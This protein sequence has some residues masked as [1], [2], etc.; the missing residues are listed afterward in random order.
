MNKKVK[1]LLCFIAVPIVI[2]AL[3]GAF[4][5][6]IWLIEKLSYIIIP[7]VV[8]GLWVCAATGLYKEML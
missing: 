3:V 4:V 6:I 2:A 8:L 7:L 5:G 1:W